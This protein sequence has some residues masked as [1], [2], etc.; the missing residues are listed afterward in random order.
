M[1]LFPCVPV[2]NE[3]NTRDVVA[4]SEMGGKLSADLWTV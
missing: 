1:G 4:K 3:V 2:A